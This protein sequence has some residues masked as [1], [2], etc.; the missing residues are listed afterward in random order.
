MIDI[1]PIHRGMKWVN[2]IRLRVIVFVIG[3]PLAAWGAIMVGPAWLA[4]P[5][6]GVAVACVTMSVSRIT[7]RMAATTC[8]TCGHDLKG[9][10]PH[11]HGIACPACGS[12]NQHNPEPML[13][14]AAI[15][16]D[17]QPADRDVA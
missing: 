6:V 17:E 14:D 16:S 1:D 9:I 4:L 15:E 11:E 10:P 12:L 3:I 5:L 7:Q 2:R 8:F 13:A